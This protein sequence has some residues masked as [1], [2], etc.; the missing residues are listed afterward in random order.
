LMS[1]MESLSSFVYLCLG[2]GSFNAATFPAL[3]LEL[4]LL[5]K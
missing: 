3:T 2:N 1:L 5:K 4:T